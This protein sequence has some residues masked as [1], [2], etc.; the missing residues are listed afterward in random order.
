ML[1]VSKSDAEPVDERLAVLGQRLRDLRKDAGLNQ[2]ALAERA[3]LD[4]GFLS[5]VERGERN[6]GVLKLFAVCDALGVA[7]GELF[8]DF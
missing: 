6:I 2:D 4:R 7:V 8:V 5:S 3:Q 1:T